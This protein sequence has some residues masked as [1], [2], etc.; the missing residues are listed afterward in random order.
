MKYTNYI[1]W[2]NK[3]KG[4]K[5]INLFNCDYEIIRFTK[6]DQTNTIENL[7]VNR[8]TKRNKCQ[9]KRTGREVDL[10]CADLNRERCY[11]YLSRTK[12]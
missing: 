10:T 9:N 8:A 7:L 4:C 2:R 6:T 11:S 12:K 3:E 5:K 1:K